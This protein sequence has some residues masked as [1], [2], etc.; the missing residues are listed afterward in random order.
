MRKQ[1]TV[2]IVDDDS[3]MRW[4]MRNVLS[5]AGFGVA[6]SDGGGTALEQA[7]L[8]PPAAVLLD[9]LVLMM[10][11]PAA[12]LTAQLPFVSLKGRVGS[13]F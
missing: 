2:L 7:A 4:A 6:E 13:V 5:D 9:K 1:A 10:D 3:D 12:K 8:D 11:G